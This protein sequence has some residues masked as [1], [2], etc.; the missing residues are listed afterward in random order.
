MTKPPLIAPPLET[1]VEVHWLDAH[2]SVQAEMT[3]DEIAVQTLTIYKTHGKLVRFDEDVIAVAG[4]ERDDGRYRGI[5][6]IPAG[7]VQRI[8]SR[9]RWKRAVVE[10]VSA[11]CPTESK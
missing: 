9:Q 7:M 2:A 3:L 5:T 4:D 10:P 6:F 1:R 11:E 8:I